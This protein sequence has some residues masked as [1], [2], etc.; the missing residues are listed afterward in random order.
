M[1]LPFFY[2]DMETQK[3]P[4]TIWVIFPYNLSNNAD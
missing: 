1:P 4:N 3:T 2:K